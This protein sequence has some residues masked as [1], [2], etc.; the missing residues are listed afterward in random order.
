MTI[1][2]TPMKTLAFAFVLPIFSLCSLAVRG[3]YAIG[4]LDGNDVRAAFQVNGML[5]YDHNLGAPLYRVPASLTGPS[6]ILSGNLWIG[7]LLA[8]SVLHLAA[9]RFEQVGTDFFPGP[10]GTGAG[11]TQA[12]SDLYNH[13]WKVN[14]SD[15]YTHIAYFNCLND[16]NCD[17]QVD[18]PGYAAPAYFHEWPAH[19]DASMGQAFHLA[20]FIDYNND[21]S[22]DPDDGDAPCVP[23]DQ[24]LF[25]IFND[26]LAP[27]TES[28]GQPIGLEVHLMPFGVNG[29]PALEQ[30]VFVRYRLFNRSSTTMYN[31]Y[32]GLWNDFDLGGSNDDYV[33][34]DVGR[35]LVFVRNG[36]MNDEGADGLPGYGPN[37][38]AFGEVILQGPL[39]D[40]DGSDNTDATALPGFNGSGFNDGV[41]DNERLGLGRSLYFNNA[42]GPMGD[43]DVPSEYYG[44]MKGLWGDGTPMTYGGSGYSTDPNAV[45][46]RFIFPGNSDPLGVGTNG[47]VMP[48]WTETSAGNAPGDRRALASVGPFTFQPGQ[49][50]D[51]LVAYVF[52]HDDNGSVDALLQ[53]VDSV[54]AYAE[55]QPGLLAPGSPCDELLS[56]GI[57]GLSAPRPALQAY[58]NPASELLSVSVPAG[59]GNLVLE[60]IDARG[61]LVRQQKA[62]AGPV[63]LSIHD[64]M[65]GLYLLRAQGDASVKPVRFVKQ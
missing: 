48:A 31:T 65:P 2:H 54:R 34:C 63:K 20:D 53:R 38:P 14:R 10:L 37:P 46:A 6:P 47:Q 62:T 30:T 11:I 29:Q 25:S 61:Q 45:P 58:P 17:V 7:G 4:T 23:G 49:E 42:S 39:M 28:G 43:P 22:Y 1:I 60:V 8:D 16:P 21:G 36:D 24:A 5:T 51:L 40:P 32:I 35:N 64:L 13:V 9:E 52:A 41:V 3:Q 44:M 56:A 55:A 18:F 26:N 59:T 27:H 12:T 33:Q 19:G 15:V 57:T 50:Q